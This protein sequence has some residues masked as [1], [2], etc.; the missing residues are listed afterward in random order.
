VGVFLLVAVGLERWMGDD[1]L[2]CAFCL[3]NVLRGLTLGMRL[4][5]IERVFAET[6]AVS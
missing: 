6:A 5:R 2:W 3:F 4:P 1:G